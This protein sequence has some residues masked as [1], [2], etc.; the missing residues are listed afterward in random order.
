MAKKEVK[1]SGIG[2]IE[3]RARELLDERFPEWE[4]QPSSLS[5]RF[6]DGD[7]MKTHL[8]KSVSVVKHLA[9]CFNLPAEDKDLLIAGALLHDIGKFV[10]TSD[11]SI[12]RRGW[13]W[14]PQT[15]YSRLEA[16]MKIHGPVG[17]ATLE[18][19]K[20]PRKDE[21]K[22]LIA[23]HMGHWNEN[24]PQPQTLYQHLIAIAD[25]LSSRT[26]SKEGSIFEYKDEP[27]E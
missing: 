26:T 10:I 15:K 9:D 22:A 18:D 23:S 1:D 7:R 8:E 14:F 4:N 2:P 24:S 13:K 27:D 20:I 5:G 16:L 19:Y 17:A 6:H 3:E 21:L 12:E 25:Y 11:V